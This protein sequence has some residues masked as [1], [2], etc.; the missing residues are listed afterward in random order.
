MHIDPYMKYFYVSYFNL[1]EYE[2]NILQ[3]KLSCFCLLH[4]LIINGSTPMAVIYLNAMY[5][6]LVYPEPDQWRRKG[7]W[8]WAA[9]W[10]H[11]DWSAFPLF[12][13]SWRNPCQ[14]LL[15]LAHGPGDVGDGWAPPSCVSLHPLANSCTPLHKWR[16]LVSCVPF[17][18][19]S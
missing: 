13:S 12:W 19:F 18:P 14:S 3:D 16:L 15:S 11:S 7:M 10:R 2:L 5:E 1:M 6:E 17:L 8:V 9:P 4:F